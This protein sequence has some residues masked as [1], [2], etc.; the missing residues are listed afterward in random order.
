[1]HKRHA[2][3]TVVQDRLQKLQF[4]L[5]IRDLFVFEKPVL[6]ERSQTKID[7]AQRFA[8]KGNVFMS[9]AC[10]GAA[11]DYANEAGILYPYQTPPRSGD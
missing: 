5:R 2:K 10:V 8:E 4:E 6:A 9:D 11:E 7:D 3:V 1:M